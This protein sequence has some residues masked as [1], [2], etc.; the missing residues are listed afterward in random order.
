M[1]RRDAAAAAE[2][3][4][5]DRDELVAVYTAHIS[6]LEQ[7]NAHLKS[8]QFIFSFHFFFGGGGVYLSCCVWLLP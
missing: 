1:L 5:R 8:A 3:A 2:V 7:T 4:A 6:D